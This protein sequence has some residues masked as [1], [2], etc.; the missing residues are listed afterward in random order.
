MTQE[1]TK[2]YYCFAHSFINIPPSSDMIGLLIN[3][4]NE[5]SKH[6]EWPEVERSV[7]YLANKK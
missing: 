4:I 6:H 3:A 1:S 2:F 5:I 7:I